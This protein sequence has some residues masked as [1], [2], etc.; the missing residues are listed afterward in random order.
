MTPAPARALAGLRVVDCSRLIA[1]GVL[2]TV[3]ADHGADVIKVENPRGGDP[4]RTWLRERGQLWWKVYARG[5]RS[6]TLNLGAPRG[7]ELLKR[8][9]S[10]ADVLIEN[11]VPGTFERW[12]LGWDAL[13]AVNPRLVFARVSGWGQDGPYRDRP[14][15]GTMVEAMSGFAATTGAAD[16]P[17]TLPSF[18]M[19][20]MFAALAGAT[21]VLAAL[22]HRDQVSGRG[23]VLDISLYEPLLSVLGPD[24]ARYAQDGT[25]RTR[26]G[27]QSDNASPR[28]TY[29][30]RDGRWVAL[31]A[32]TPASAQALFKGLGLGDLLDDP[33]FATNDA[34]VQHNDQVD[35]A[36]VK[37]IGRRTLDEMV[38]LFETID[39][40][41]SPVYDIADIAK[42]PHVVARGILADVPD[43]E[44]GQVRMIAPTPRL[45][46]SPAAIGWTGP[47]L[48][49]HNREVYGAL[50]LSDAELVAL[51]RDGVI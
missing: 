31:S 3:L 4:L 24:A 43:A 18:P 41:A 2:A 38:E 6:I 17:P 47:P 29:Q 19:A 23:Q 44:L 9:V 11:F 14:G 50:G 34:R 13:S 16:G 40:T 25:V 48:G 10:D 49:A 42:D 21:A 32:S 7:Q 51:H 15:F 27:N 5:K 20:D 8:L 36:L 12:G 35:A 30:T 39:L 37:A 45:S 46:D 1:G 33:R 26:H 22:R 28:G